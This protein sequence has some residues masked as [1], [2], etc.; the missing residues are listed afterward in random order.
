MKRISKLALCALQYQFEAM[1]VHTIVQITHKYNHTKTISAQRQVQT[2]VAEFTHEG[3]WQRQ[4][5]PVTPWWDSNPCSQSLAT[6]ALDRY[7]TEPPR[8]S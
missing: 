8:K 4:E 6:S 1:N 3:R 2:H 7:A 5:I